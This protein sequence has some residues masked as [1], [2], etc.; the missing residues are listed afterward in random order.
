M[1]DFWMFMTTLAVGAA[2]LAVASTVFRAAGYV[3]DHAGGRLIGLTHEQIDEIRRS[4]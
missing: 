2:W 4:R 3:T 1:T